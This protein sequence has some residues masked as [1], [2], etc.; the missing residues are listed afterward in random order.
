LIMTVHGTLRVKEN[1]VYNSV[2][3]MMIYWYTSVKL[4]VRER[5]GDRVIRKKKSKMIFK[6]RLCFTD[7]KETM[8]H[9]H[10]TDDIR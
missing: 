6:K 4:T 8:V 1:I 7:V 5:D 9:R 3:E 10:T 2:K